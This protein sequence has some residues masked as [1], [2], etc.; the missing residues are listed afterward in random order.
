MEMIYL[1]K[2]TEFYITWNILAEKL[3]MKGFQLDPCQ[4]LYR[5]DKPAW[6]I[7][8]TKDSA[9]V[10]SDFYAAHGKTVPGIVLDALR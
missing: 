9:A 1:A 7:T 10:I 8:I 2:R 3:S 4:N 6:K 5:P